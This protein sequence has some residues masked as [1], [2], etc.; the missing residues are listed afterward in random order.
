MSCLLQITESLQRMMQD[1]GVWFTLNACG[2][3]LSISDAFKKNLG[4][5]KQTKSDPAEPQDT[6][7][8]KLH[9]KINERRRA[10]HLSD[11]PQVIKTPIT[12]EEK[13]LPLRKCLNTL[14]ETESKAPVRREI[15][16]IRKEE[17]HLNS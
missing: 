5:K 1:L 6:S 8:K 7:N 13:L 14:C 10:V 16:L 11:L 15:Q 12:M 4:N 3:L 17:T 2:P 9:M